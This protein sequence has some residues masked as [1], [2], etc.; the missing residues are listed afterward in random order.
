L[1]IGKFTANGEIEVNFNQKVNVPFKFIKVQGGSARL[2]G[3]E[4]GITFDQLNI[5]DIFN[6]YIIQ[7]S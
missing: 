5:G 1:D 6:S 3:S 7:K 4:N 2:L